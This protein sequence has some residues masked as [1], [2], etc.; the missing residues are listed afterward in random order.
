MRPSN[1]YNPLALRWLNIKQALNKS[2]TK[3]IDKEEAFCFSPYSYTPKGIMKAQL[4]GELNEEVILVPQ[5][6]RSPKVETLLVFVVPTPYSLANGSQGK[7]FQPIILRGC[8][9]SLCTTRGQIGSLV[10]YP[11]RVR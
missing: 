10:L 1:T 9:D 2:L 4:F 3:V 6:A 5:E 11:A 8:Y 7:T